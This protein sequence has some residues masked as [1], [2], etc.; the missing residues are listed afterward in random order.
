MGNRT[1]ADYIESKIGKD[2]FPLL[3]K[4]LRSEEAK[5]AILN[6]IKESGVKVSEEVLLREILSVGK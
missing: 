1:I 6:I 5:F 3:D 2:V 4:L